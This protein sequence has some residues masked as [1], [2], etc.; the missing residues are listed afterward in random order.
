MFYQ[1]SGHPLA[2]SSW[3]IKLTIHITRNTFWHFLLY[4]K[5][6]RQ[7]CLTKLMSWSPNGSWT[8]VWK[9]YSDMCT[10]HLLIWICLSSL[11]HWS[12]Q[13]GSYQLA[14][15]KFNLISM[16]L[17]SITFKTKTNFQKFQ[18]ET[19]TCYDPR[20]SWGGGWRG[21]GNKQKVVQHGVYMPS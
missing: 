13:T 9:H 21:T 5:L 14:R 6:K 3:H 10:K 1:L 2:Q 20:L 8:E 11:L 15:D 12:S 19:C 18:M 4:L 17:A 16:W 7:P